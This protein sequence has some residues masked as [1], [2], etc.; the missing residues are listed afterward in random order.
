MQNS[1][2]SHLIFLQDK[3]QELTDSLTRQMDDVERAALQSKIELATLALEHFRRAY[4][5]ELKLREDIPLDA[6]D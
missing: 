5:I 3:L 1:L 2:R 4:D 6:R